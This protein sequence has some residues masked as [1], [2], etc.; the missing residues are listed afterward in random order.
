V[1]AE[2]VDE[3]LVRMRDRGLLQPC[4][5]SCHQQYFMKVDNTAIPLSIASCFAEA[6]E[7]VLARKLSALF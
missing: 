2:T 6:V 3:A 1:Q 4:L 7:Q 5:F